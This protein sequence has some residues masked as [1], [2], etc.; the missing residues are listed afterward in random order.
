MYLTMTEL[1]HYLSE[2][3]GQPVTVRQIF[4]WHDRRPNSGFPLPKRLEERKRGKPVPVFDREEV[5]AWRLAYVP[6]KGGYQY[7]KRHQEATA[8]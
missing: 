5:L 2:R 7:H 4:A 6:K 3:L 1:A 8:A